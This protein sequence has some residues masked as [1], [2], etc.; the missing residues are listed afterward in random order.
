MPVIEDPWIILALVL[1]ILSTIL[2][3]VY[4]LTHWNEDIRE[5]E[6]DMTLEEEWEKEEKNE[7]DSL[8]D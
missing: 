5:E 2:G 1:S 6:Q 4:G 3:V 8:L 7:V